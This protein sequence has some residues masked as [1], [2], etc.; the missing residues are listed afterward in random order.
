MENLIWRNEREKERIESSQQNRRRES[1][2]MDAVHSTKSFQ[3]LAVGGWCIMGVGS[4]VRG[5]RSG[6]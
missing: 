4:K 1:F 3:Q 2:R 5:Q 6:V